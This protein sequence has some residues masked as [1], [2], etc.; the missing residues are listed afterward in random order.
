M[1]HHNGGVFDVAIVTGNVDS[2]R[3]L[4]KMSRLFGSCPTTGD[5]TSLKPVFEL[6]I[7]YPKNQTIQAKYNKSCTCPACSVSQR[8][9]ARILLSADVK[10]LVLLYTVRAGLR[11]A[12]PKIWGTS[13]LKR[14]L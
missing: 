4:F 11:P 9:E 12:L 14:E 7:A 6:R 3:Q 5:K 10:R 2:I 8:M 13:L 1:A